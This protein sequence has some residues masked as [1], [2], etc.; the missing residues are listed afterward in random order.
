[1]IDKARAEAARARMRKRM[2]E[3]YG[4]G[5][6]TPTS[7]R[8]CTQCGAALQDGVKFCGACGTK[9]EQAQF[10]TECGSKLAAGTKFCG[11]CGAKSGGNVPSTK[12]NDAAATAPEKAPV[13]S[14]R[15]T[16]SRE[17]I[18]IITTASLSVS[19]FGDA[20]A[21]DEIGYEYL[22]ENY[23]DRDYEDVV[24]GDDDYSRKGLLSDVLRDAILFHWDQGDYYKAYENRVSNIKNIYINVAMEKYSKIE[25]LS[26]TG[27][28]ILDMDYICD[29]D[30]ICIVVEME[31][32]FDFRSEN[33]RSL[34][35]FS[36]I[37]E[38]CIKIYGMC[39]GNLV[40]QEYSGGDYEEGYFSNEEDEF[41]VVGDP[42]EYPFLSGLN[43]L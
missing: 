22:S 21:L 20:E 6:S 5:A 10:C 23:D 29:N 14:G 2:E 42:S 4:R 24:C 1:M 26:N 34:L 8:S 30:E 43:I 18:V 11:E 37:T 15:D 13:T 7:S 33:D 12:P 9:V 31:K 36:N 17:N 16:F 40:W 19:H 3:R 41:Y 27:E 35:K 32:R 28:S 38:E 25:E 39:D